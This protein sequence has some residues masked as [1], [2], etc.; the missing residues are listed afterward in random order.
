M[1]EKEGLNCT[2]CKSCKLLKSIC[3]CDEL[4]KYPDVPF[5]DLL[6]KKIWE[7]E[8]EGYKPTDVIMYA[9]LYLYYENELFGSFW[10]FRLKQHIL[11]SFNLDVHLVEPVHD[12]YEGPMF[13]VFC[14]SYKK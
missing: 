14:D 4:K 8:D 12:K 10:G 11:E 6:D 1:V 5:D 2:E 13:M 3:V 7:I 9:P